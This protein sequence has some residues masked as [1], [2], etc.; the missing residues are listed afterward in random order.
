MANCQWCVFLE[1]DF[2]HVPGRDVKYYNQRVCVSAYVHWYVWK[3]TCPNFM[4]RAASDHCS[5]F[6]VI[7]VQFVLYFHT[8]SCTSIQYLHCIHPIHP[9]VCVCVCAPYSIFYR[10]LRHHRVWNFMTDSLIFST[11]HHCWF[12]IHLQ[13]NCDIFVLENFN[14]FILKVS[15]FGLYDCCLY[16]LPT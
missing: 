12:T 13:F 7:T 15:N 8:V 4:F 16:W 2:Y 10:Q 3:A 5:V 14:I 11:N 9:F 6:F 1:T